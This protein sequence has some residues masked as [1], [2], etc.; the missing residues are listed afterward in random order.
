MVCRFSGSILDALLWGM[1]RVVT[2]LGRMSNDV[3]SMVVAADSS[4]LGFVVVNDKM[5][6]VRVTAVMVVVV[7]M[8]GSTWDVPFDFASDDE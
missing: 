8:T 6:I 4:T 3:V 1:I 5:M 7:V 2:T